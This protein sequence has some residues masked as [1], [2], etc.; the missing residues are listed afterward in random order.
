[1]FWFPISIG[2]RF[3]TWQLFGKYPAILTDEVVGEQAT[4]VFADAQEMLAVIL[5]ET[6]C[7]SCLR[8]FSTNQINDDDIELTD[9]N[10]TITNILDIASTVSKNQRFK[11]CLPDFIA[12]KT[13]ELQIIWAVLCNHGFW[14]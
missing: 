4:S 11:Y 14:C 9:E 12:P 6:N 10:G 1:M 13:M 2:H 5:K 3:R 8:H 7:Q